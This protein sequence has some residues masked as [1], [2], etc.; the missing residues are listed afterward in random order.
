M[1]NQ[2]IKTLLDNVMS[3]DEGDSISNM[4]LQHGHSKREPEI[5]LLNYVET[6]R[7]PCMRFQVVAVSEDNKNPCCIILLLAIVFLRK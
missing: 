6:V 5:L 2:G 3:T 7:V 4:V 1:V